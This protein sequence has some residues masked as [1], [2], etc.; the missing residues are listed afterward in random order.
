ML[1]ARVRGRKPDLPSDP[2]FHCPAELGHSPDSHRGTNPLR[3]AANRAI[4]VWSARNS[5]QLAPTQV[6]EPGASL[7]ADLV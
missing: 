5:G 1:T 3:R 6:S 2:A 7:S 4:E